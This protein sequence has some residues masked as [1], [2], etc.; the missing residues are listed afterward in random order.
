MKKFILTLSALALSATLTA[1][2][3]EKALV[4]HNDDAVHVIETEAPTTVPKVKPDVTDVKTIIAPK[5]EAKKTSATETATNS[6]VGEDKSENDNTTTT[7]AVEN[8]ADIPAPEASDNTDNPIEN[9]EKPTENS[10]VPDEYYI[11]EGIVYKVDK[12]SILIDEVDL[13]LMNIGFADKS[14]VNSVKAGDKV[15]VKYDGVVAESYPSQVSKAYA[16]EVTE[17]AEQTYKVQNFICENETVDLSFSLL[18]PDGWTTKQI[19]YPTEGDFTDWGFRIMPK[20]E[21]TGLDISWHSAFSIREPFDVFPETINKINVKK[22]SAEGNWR[23]YTFENDY[24]ASNNFFDTN[25]YDKYAEE[26]EF[27]L[28]TLKFNEVEFL[29]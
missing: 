8:P 18:L 29:G 25:L 11:L 22:Y 9:S 24:I 3:R 14:A 19:E 4:E 17:K 15:K 16:V 23:F 1:C 7:E 6:A 5:T 20:G 21:E 10:A 28:S 2:G 12:G 26:F 13:N 27:I